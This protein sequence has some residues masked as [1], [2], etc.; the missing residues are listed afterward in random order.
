MEYALFKIKGKYPRTLFV[1]PHIK[2]YI[3]DE[4]WYSSS[5]GHI[6]RKIPGTNK[7]IGLKQDILQCEESVYF[8]N[9]DTSDYRICNLA[10]GKEVRKNGPIPEVINTQLN[11]PIEEEPEELNPVQQPRHNVSFQE[12]CGGNI[13]NEGGKWSVDLRI[14]GI[15]LSAGAFDSAE[16]LGKVIDSLCNA[17]NN[18]T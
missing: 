15:T 4:K 7:T 8:L 18:Q 2:K 16:S 9:K 1:D 14:N 12:D 13:R 10:T 17:M 3:Q 6:Y 11:P 5:D